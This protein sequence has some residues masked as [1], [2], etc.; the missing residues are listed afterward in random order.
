[1]KL[2]ALF[3][4][5][6]LLNILLFNSCYFVYIVWFLFCSMLGTLFPASSV[7]S[8]AIVS[9]V[10]HCPSRICLL[11]MKLCKLLVFTMCDYLKHGLYFKATGL[12]QGA[13]GAHMR[14]QELISH[15]S[16]V[17]AYC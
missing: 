14:N 1:M 8:C 4:T 11:T 17:E 15:L 2:K 13:N 12:K 10:T 3:W 16:G 7:R 6:N 9:Y 5:V